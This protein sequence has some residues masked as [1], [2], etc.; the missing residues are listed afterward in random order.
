MVLGKFEGEC[1]EKKIE[2]KSRKKKKWK[3]NKKYI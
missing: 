1:D 3:E 2:K